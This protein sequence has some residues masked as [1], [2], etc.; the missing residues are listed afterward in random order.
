[1]RLRR[2]V[3]ADGALA[4]VTLIWGSTFVLVKDAVEQVSP[5]LLLA[6]R[7]TLGALAL[8]III[9]LLGRWRGV[10]LREVGWGALM[11]V[12]LGTG[13]ALQTMGLQWTSASNA[14]F[15]TG[16]YVVFVPVLGIIFLKQTPDRWGIT[17]IALATL[18]LALLS[19]RSETGFYLN[20]G[21]LLMLGCA[22]AFAVQI[23]VVA[24]VAGWADPLRM[25]LVQIAVAGLLNALGAALFER[26]VAAMDPQLW[27]SA[28]YLG[29]AA[30]SL[31]FT[32]Q[33]TVQRFTSALHTA[34][35]FTLEPV[36]A[37]FFGVWLQHDRLG[38]AA[39]AGA[40]MILAGMILGQGSEIGLAPKP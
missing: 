21:D 9:A 36:F 16:L 27:A 34:L 39:W 33:I 4:L 19:L 18:G 13:Y 6:L 3:L 32:I 40:A 23:V 24:R 37:A 22:A 11:G 25:T 10:T 8:V 31:A 30:T 7:F 28:A 17:G 29:V 1:M 2:Q 26:P 38:V 5:L 15:I 35:I 20:S 14:G 12:A